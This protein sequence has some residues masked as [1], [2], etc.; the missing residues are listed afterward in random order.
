MNK[1]SLRIHYLQ[2][3]SYETP[4]YILQWAQEN[5]HQISSTKFYENE[6]LPELTDFDWLIIMGGPMSIGDENEY[7]WLKTEKA[8]IKSAIDNNR[9]VI[10]ICL[11]SQLIA[12]V[13]GAKVY[14]NNEKEIGWWPIQ[15]DKAS[16]NYPLVKHLPKTLTVFHWHGDTFELPQG[17]THL[18]YSQACKNQGFIY[19]DRALGLQFHFETTPETLKSI[20]ENSRNELTDGIYIQPEK[21]MMASIDKCNEANNYLAQILNYLV[22]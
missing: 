9:T 8:F 1:K 21:E 10:G 22:K 14:P 2:H 13:L 18:F 6:N 5:G 12:N 16:M 11:G 20:V 3:V 15:K 17:T 7:P 19:D 4:G